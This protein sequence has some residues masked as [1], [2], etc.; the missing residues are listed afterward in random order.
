VELQQIENQ[1]DGV[2]KIL[3]RNGQ[4]LAEDRGVPA[5]RNGVMYFTSSQGLHAVDLKTQ[6][7]LWMLEQKGLLAAQ[8]LIVQ[9]A[10]GTGVVYFGSAKGLLSQQ[11]VSGAV[12]GARAKFQVRIVAGGGNVAV[13][14][15]P[16]QPQAEDK[17]E[18]PQEA[19]RY[20]LSALRLPVGAKS[21][22]APAGK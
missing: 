12:G 4:V 13:Q 8:P 10:D 9:G 18:Q 2:R 5:I 20:G 7:E 3:M 17:D 11:I 21:A 16:A 6:K 1:Q 15:V 19:A 22:E 14:P